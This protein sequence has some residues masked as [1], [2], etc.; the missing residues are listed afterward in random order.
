MKN[1][2]NIKALVFIDDFVG[3]GDT[4]SGYLKELNTTHSE[5]INQKEIQ[6]FFVAVIAFKRGWQQI[7]KVADSLKFKINAKYCELI[8]EEACCFSEKSAIFTNQNE[9]EKAKELAWYY[10]HK[11]E[12]NCP[13]GYGDL[14]LAFVFERSCPNNS[15]PIL[16][17]E[18]VNPKWVPLF[19]RL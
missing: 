14:E 18:S 6:V 9:R 16:W 4:V 17:S 2:H 3:T 11:L 10:G 8:D 1:N 13:L 7:E 15:L 12:K 5:I 19:K